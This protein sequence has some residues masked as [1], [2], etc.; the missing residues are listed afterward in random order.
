MLNFKS[1][2]KTKSVFAVL[3]EYYLLFKRDQKMTKTTVEKKVF[4]AIKSFS[5]VRCDD[6][7]QDLK[8]KTN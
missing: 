4:L 8:N 2:I 7:R 3:E 5:R 6:F 1:K